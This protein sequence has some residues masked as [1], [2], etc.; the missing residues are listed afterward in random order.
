MITKQTNAP[1]N[2]N[3]PSAVNIVVSLTHDFYGAALRMAANSALTLT[4]MP[5][6]VYGFSSFE[7][8]IF[9]ALSRP[10]STQVDGMVDGAST[11]LVRLRSRRH[12][13][14]RPNT[15]SS[16]PA[17][18]LGCRRIQQNL[19][20]HQVFSVIAAPGALGQGYLEVSDPWGYSGLC[21]AKF[22]DSRFRGNPG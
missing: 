9:L 18:D 17:V 15:A 22:L 7:L 14:R 19:E 8:V 1:T 16:S 3:P 5:W 10:K 11:T 13:G 4:Y 21:L 6:Q 2:I 20:M 12:A